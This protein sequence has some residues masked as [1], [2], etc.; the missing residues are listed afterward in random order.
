MQFFSGAPTAIGHSFYTLPEAQLFLVPT[1]MSLIP[2]P[3]MDFR[4]AHI[5]PFFFLTPIFFSF[6][7]GCHVTTCVT[8]YSSYH[9]LCDVTLVCSGTFSFVLPYLVD[10]LSHLLEER[11]GWCRSKV[12]ENRS[13][14]ESSSLLVNILKLCWSLLLFQKWGCCMHCMSIYSLES[15]D[16]WNKKRKN[17]GR[18]MQKK[19]NMMLHR[20]CLFRKLN[21]FFLLHFCWSCANFL[22]HCRHTL[23]HHQFSL[24]HYFSFFSCHQTPATFRHGLSQPI[25]VLSFIIFI[26]FAHE[27]S[28]GEKNFHHLQKVIFI[29]TLL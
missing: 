12:L 20:C 23:L 16:T 5:W 19:K 1:G 8:T 7:F 26:Y 3:S 27:W 24:S 11:N 29:G 15:M 4:V 10:N 18:F 13:P 17:C 9:N 25:C 22:K 28:F 2:S 21:L 6:F 14:S